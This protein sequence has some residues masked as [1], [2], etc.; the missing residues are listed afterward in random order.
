MKGRRIII[1]VFW[2]ENFIILSFGVWGLLKFKKR[3]L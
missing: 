1:K 3:Y 2:I